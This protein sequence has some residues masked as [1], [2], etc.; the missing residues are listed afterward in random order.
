MENEEVTNWVF[1]KCSVTDSWRAAK[2]EH[3]NDICNSFGSSNVIK[4]RDIN[5]LIEL[6][7]K[8]NGNIP[9]MN[10]LMKR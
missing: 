4:S 10:K 2:K 6:I 5:V 7:N 1:N 9:E 3:Y 8:T